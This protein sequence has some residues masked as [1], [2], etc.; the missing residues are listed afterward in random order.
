MAYGSVKVD[1]IVGTNKTLTTDNVVTTDDTGTV[2]STMIS[3]GTI[4]NGDINASA[5][6]A[7]TK[8]ATISTAGKVSNS[9]TTATDGNTASAI[10]ARDASGN[11]SAGTVTAALSGNATTASA[12]ATARTI[13]LGGDVSGSASFDGSANVTI[14]A[15]VA[16]DSH[17]H[18]VSNVD[19]LQSALDAKAPL[20]SP[21]LTGVPTAP[22]AA[23]GTNTT[24]VAT[25]A[26]VA[27]AVASGVAGVIDAAPAALDTLNELAAALGD[28]ASFSTTVTNSI[29]TKLPLS[30]GQMTGNITF[31]STQTVDGRDLSVDGAKLDGI[32]SGATADQTAS[33]ILTAIKT[34]DGAGSGLDADTLDGVEGASYAQLAS[35]TFTGTPAAPTAAVGTNTTQLATTA[36]VNAEIANDAPTKTGGGASGTWG[37]NVTGNAGTATTL[38]TARTIGGV[39]FD[40]SASINLPGVNTTG[41]QNTSGSSASCTGN[42][43]TATTLQTARTINGVSFNGSANITVEPYVEDDNTTNASRYVIFTDNSTGGFKR[44]NEDSNFY[45]NPSTNTLTASTFSGSLSGNASTSSSCTGNAATATSLQTAR[46]ISLTGDLNGTASFDGSA[47][48]SISTQ[49]NDNS[50]NHVISNV[51]NL[52]SSL[53]AKAALGSA[54]TFTAAQRGTVS[55]LSS[56]SSITPNFATA[57]NFSLSLGTNTTINNPSNLTAGQSGAIAITYSGAYTVAFGSYWKFAGGTAPT[58]TSTSGKTDLLVYYVESSTRISAQLLLNMGG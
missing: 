8:L 22:T 48:I 25:T 30:G 28:D 24:Q 44:L 1:T 53:D 32:E 11:F 18:V 19:G 17:A 35:P 46:S 3:D 4:V 2:T 58:A 6:I 42:A 51:S 29:A 9:A 55:S 15:T 34:V 26:F 21:A 13:A 7:D 41:N 50:H 38:Q 57:N 23:T 49:V 20:A 31:S 36:F 16:D 52:Q 27:T 43:A 54:Q 37:I 45:Y 12:L 56:S 39:S 14:T 47:N 10:V 40:G 5:A 33:E